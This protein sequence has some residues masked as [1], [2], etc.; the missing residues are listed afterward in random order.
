LA[1]YIEENYLDKPS[2]VDRCVNLSILN[3]VWLMVASTRYEADDKVMKK[4]IAAINETI[5]INQGPLM[6]VNNLPWIAKILPSTVYHKWT[7]ESTMEK[8]KNNFY[9]LYR[10]LIEEHKLN[11][12]ENDP[13]DIIDQYLVEKRDKSDEN[14]SDLVVT[15]WDMF[16]AGSD[17]TSGT[18]RWFILYMALYPEV[19][20]KIHAEMDSVVGEQAPTL[21]DRQRLPYL[22]AS[23]L[24]V[25]RLSSFVQLGLPHS[26]TETV[27][28]GGYT[29]PKDTIVNG[30][31][32]LIHRDPRYWENPNTLYPEHFLDAEGK[33]SQK[34]EAFM[35]FS[36][37][38]RACLGESLA[39]MEIYLFTTA[40]LHRFRIEQVP[41]DDL[42]DEPMNDQIGLNF[43]KP[44]KVIFRKRF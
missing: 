6:L 23:A 13:R 7:R 14:Y 9:G 24:D 5:I 22:E 25:M 30:I 1:D 36:L 38:K 43:P 34:N 8:N 37:G 11:L 32:F 15:M 4:F 3:V 20:R 31:F 42:K 28:L 40:L 17:T 10:E 12:D 21:A 33:L 26:A 16:V 39:R 29:I 35:P 41:G 18:L 2:E 27:E 44:Y 19:Q